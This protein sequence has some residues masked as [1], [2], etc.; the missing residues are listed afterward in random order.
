LW[1]GMD[2]GDRRNPDGRSKAVWQR[3][4]MPPVGECAVC[5]NVRG[6]RVCRVACFRV[7]VER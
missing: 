4:G 2:S 6:R 5:N 3:G 7:Y 1:G